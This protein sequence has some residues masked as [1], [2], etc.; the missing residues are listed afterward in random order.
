MTVNLQ[1]INRY[2]TKYPEDADKVVLSVKGAV[3]LEKHL[4][5]DSSPENIKKSID[6][7]LSILDGKKSLDIF[8]PA[9]VDPK[10]RI[11]D[12]VSVIAE[13]IKAGKL[14]GIALSE[15]SAQTIHRAAKVH[16]ITAV[17]VEYSLFSTDIRDNGV[18]DACKEH[19]IIIVA[20]SPVGA[21]F[22][23]GQIKSLDDFPKDDH[24]RSFE[25]FQPENFDKNFELVHA[26]KKLAD[27]K[28]VSSA[29]LALEW[30]RKQPLVVPIPG[31]RAV[32]RTAEN[33]AKVD[34][35]DV[36]YEELEKILSS[37]K[38]EGVR[39]QKGHPQ[40]YGDSA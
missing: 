27:R 13:Y 7:I 10:V 39:Y 26:V 36:E 5:P 25:R 16:K 11:E 21:G 14:G 34:L 9:R 32:N 18:Y 30:C 33:T 24:R 22:L 12:T 17:E 4:A 40:L 37:F 38:P 28:G 29:Q 1:L 35:S 20:Y 8:E 2:F 19:D 6:N 15:C 3:N 31:T 23:T